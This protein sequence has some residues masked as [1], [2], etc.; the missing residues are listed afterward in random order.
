MRN[1]VAAIQG[2]VLAQEQYTQHEPLTLGFEQGA[3]A[4]P[5]VEY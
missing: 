3:R 2:F 5:C 4:S 1:F